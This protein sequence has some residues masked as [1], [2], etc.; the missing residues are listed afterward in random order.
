MAIQW[1]SYNG[2][3]LAAEIPMLDITAIPDN[4]YVVGERG[5]N[6]VALSKLVIHDLAAIS[7]LPWAIRHL[8]PAVSN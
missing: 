4:F 5:G 3:P 1:P 2:Q 6:R 7:M 8:K